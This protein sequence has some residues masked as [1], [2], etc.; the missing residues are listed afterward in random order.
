M[1]EGG[2]GGGVGPGGAVGGRV[3]PPGYSRSKKR[4]LEDLFK[5][6]LDIMFQVG[7]LGIERVLIIPYHLVKGSSDVST[8]M[9]IFISLPNFTSYVSYSCSKTLAH[10]KKPVF[11]QDVSNTHGFVCTRLNIRISFRKILIS[12]LR[13]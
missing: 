9:S 6:P 8:T 5:P 3:D 11:S 2:G 7:I 4:T 10:G 12:L 1:E 13:H